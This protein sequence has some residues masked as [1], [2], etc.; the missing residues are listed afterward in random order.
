MPP[1]VIAALALWVALLFHRFKRSGAEA[2][3]ALLAAVALAF[4]LLLVIGGALHTISVAPTPLLND[5]G[6]YDTRRVWLLTIGLILVYTGLTNALLYRRI[7]RAERWALGMAATVTAL[8]LVFLLV[9]H[10]AATDETVLI[11][12]ILSPSGL[13]AMQ[14]NFSVLRSWIRLV[15]D[16]LSSIRIASALYLSAKWRTRFLR[17]G[18]SRRARTMSIK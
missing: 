17:S 18:Y 1:V 2:A 10:P 15:P 14:R 9:L 6:A 3:Y 11:R 13:M 8:L 16:P 12:V 7:R 5:V 4:G